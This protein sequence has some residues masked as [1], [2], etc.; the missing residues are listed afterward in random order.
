MAQPPVFLIKSTYRQR[1]LRDALRLLPVLGIVLLLLPLLWPEGS[2]T[3]DV[4]VYV[5]VI[6]TGLIVAGVVLIRYLAPD[7]V[8][9]DAD[10]DPHADL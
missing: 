7:H 6:W 9:T 10:A 5:F 2:R 4:L 3:R 8:D 1:R